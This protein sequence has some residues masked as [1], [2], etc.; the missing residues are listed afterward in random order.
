MAWFAARCRAWS[1]ASGASEKKEENEQ[2][3]E[4][5]RRREIL[6]EEKSYLQL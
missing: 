6:V 1:W 4:D 3:M 5:Y 2:N